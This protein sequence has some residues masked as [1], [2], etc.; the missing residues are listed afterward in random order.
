[1]R[2]HNYLIFSLNYINQEEFNEDLKV[3]LNISKNEE[4]IDLFRG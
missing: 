4:L 2:L 3:E 1:M